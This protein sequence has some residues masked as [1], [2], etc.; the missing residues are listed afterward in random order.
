MESDSLESPRPTAW[1]RRPR[2]WIIGLL[3]LALLAIIVY[4][5][6]TFLRAPPVRRGRF[7][8]SGNQPVGVA[9]VRRGDIRVTVRALGAVTPLTTVTVTPQISGILMN[10][11]FK[12]GQNVRKGQFLAQIDPRPYEIALQQ[13]QAQLARDEATLK[14]AQ[15][16][17]TRYQTLAQQNSIARQTAEDQV[18]IVKQDQ[19]T[20]DLDKAQIRTQQLNL[21]YCHIE[22]PADGRV[23]LRLVDPGNYIQAG[24]STGIV[25]LTLLHPISVIFNVA[26]DD[27]PQIMSRVHAAATLPVTA[28]DRANVT[29]LGGGTFASIDTEVDQ[30][31]GTVKLRAN[32]DN[33]DDKLFP[34]QFV[35]VQMLLD[36]LHD[37]VTI[38]ISA[39]QRGAPGTYVYLLKDD[40]TVSVHPVT[41]GAQD[42]DMV[43]VQTGLDP[44]ERVVTDGADRLRD[45]AKVV[46]PDARAARPSADGQP[47]AD[48]QPG[49]PERRNRR[50]RGQTP[51]D[52][53]QQSPSQ[54]P[55][56]QPPSQ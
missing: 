5:S 28:F 17:L 4:Q 51:A 41:L 54:A 6:I 29:Q 37:V 56:Q 13:D 44:G 31:T 15:M 52:G 11:G 1:W 39:V 30:T 2:A 8:D 33:A 35:N 53:D 18:W 7:G 20:V 16:D 43:A 45:G 23:G 36:T 26:E 50:R 34:S 46:V 24:S 38:P 21:V 25:V 14:Q 22:S 42:G 12:E 49:S 27:L 9:R 55:N 10:V 48:R 19:G 40:N 32:F 3:L 47:P